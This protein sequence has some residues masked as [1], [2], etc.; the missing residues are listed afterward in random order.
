MLNINIACVGN[1]KEKYLRD[2]SSEYSKRLSRFCKL[3][4]YEADEK[5]PEKE[6]LELLKKSEG[7]SVALCIEGGQFS[8][9]EFAEFI[10][11]AAIQLQK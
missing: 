5:N 11:K 3:N 7:F 2:A 4:I 6:K 9:E 10:K 1:L 8:S